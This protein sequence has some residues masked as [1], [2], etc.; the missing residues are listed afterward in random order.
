M[1]QKRWVQ[2]GCSGVEVLSRAICGGCQE[3]KRRL[4]NAG[5]EYLDLDVATVDGRGGAAWYDEPEVLPAAAVDGRL[6]QNAGDAD[7][8]MREIETYE[9]T[10][11]RL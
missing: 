5:I 3:L 4:Q 7:A 8:L 1:T 6:L 2:W 10:T 9:K 11:A